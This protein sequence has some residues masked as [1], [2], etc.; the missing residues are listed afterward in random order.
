M[1]IYIVCSSGLTSTLIARKLKDL[2]PEDY[3]I[4]GV[5]IELAINSKE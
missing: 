2:L 1:T 5:A 3:N 4:E